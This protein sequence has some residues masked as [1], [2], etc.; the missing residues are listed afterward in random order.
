LWCPPSRQ[1]DAVDNAIKS[2]AAECGL[3]TITGLPANL[4]VAPAIENDGN[5]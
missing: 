1:R 2:A 3:L 5:F 4:L